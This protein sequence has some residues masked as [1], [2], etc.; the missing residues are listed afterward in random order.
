MKTPYKKHRQR[1]D[2]K[3][4]DKDILTM[5]DIKNEVKTFVETDKPHPALESPEG[6]NNGAEPAIFRNKQKSRT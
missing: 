2:K 5:D 3:T 1:V 4:A 6:K